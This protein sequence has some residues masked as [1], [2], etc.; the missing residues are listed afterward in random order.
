MKIILSRKGFDSENGGYPSPIMPDGRLISLPIPSWD[1]NCYS[2]LILDNE[3]SYF[4]IM[5]Q[6]KPTIRVEKEWSEITRATHC[7]ETLIFLKMPF[8]GKQDGL[9]ALDKSLRRNVT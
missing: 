7:H 2:D 9:L 3:I 1:D 8:P 5:Q 6:L 4:D